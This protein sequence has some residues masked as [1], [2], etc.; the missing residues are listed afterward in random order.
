MCRPATSGV[1]A[2]S[3]FVANGRQ[4]MHHVSSPPSKI[5]YGGFSPVRLQTGCQPQSSP[6]RTYMRPPAQA[7]PSLCTAAQ[8]RRQ[9]PRPVHSGPEALGSPAGYSVPPG[10]RLLWPHPSLSVSPA[11]L[12]RWLIRPVF[13]D[14]AEAERFPTLLRVSVL[15]VPPSVPR[16]T[17]RWATVRSPSVIAFAQFRQARRPRLSTPVGS[18]VGVISGLQSSLYAAARAVAGPSP[19]RAFTLELSSHES[20]HWNV[21]YNYAGKQSIPRGRTLTGWTRSLMGCD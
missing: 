1:S 10:L 17:G 2:L 4:A 12:G 11:D 3:S 18:R 5:P 9:G 21:E 6:S 14:T 16:R 8:S 7:P 15:S 13:A 19:T 20:P